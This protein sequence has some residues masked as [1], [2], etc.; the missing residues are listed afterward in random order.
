V[1]IAN[2]FLLQLASLV[3]LNL[4]SAASSGGWDLD[5]TKFRCNIGFPFA[6]LVAKSISVDLSPYLYEPPN[7]WS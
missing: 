4:L 7:C 3:R 6:E 1:H 2:H 5:Q